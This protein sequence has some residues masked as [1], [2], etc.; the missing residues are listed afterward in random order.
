MKT[1][2]LAT[3]IKSRN[4]NAVIEAVRGGVEL[5][6]SLKFKLMR[7]MGMEHSI[8]YSDLRM[9]CILFVGGADRGSNEVASSL[10]GKQAS[11]R[12]DTG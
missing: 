12:S 5:N 1:S 7:M 10:Y 9:A 6:Q 3:M 4:Y 8:Y 11:H 2:E